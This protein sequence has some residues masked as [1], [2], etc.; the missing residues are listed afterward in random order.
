MERKRYLELCQRNAVFGNQCLVSYGGRVYYPKRY[1]L[2][3]N[4]AGKT[5]H[6]AILRNVDNDGVLYCNLD[7]VEEV[8]K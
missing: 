7:L 2:A 8:K 3:F 6:G 4:D 5:L 1:E